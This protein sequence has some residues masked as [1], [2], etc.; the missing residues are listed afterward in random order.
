MQTQANNAQNPLGTEKVRK[1]LPKYAVPSIVSML[2]MAIYNMVDQI[3]IGHYVGYLGNGATTVA[4]PL[5]TIMMALALMVG[6]GSAAAISLSLG[7][8]DSSACRKIIGN[9]L[10]LNLVFSGAIMAVVLT[11]MD[12]VLVFLG[13]QPNVMPYARDYVAV[14]VYGA[15][16]A[17]ISASLG[18]IIRADGSPRY[19]MVANMT[20]AISNIF[21]DWLLMGRGMGVRGAA[22]ATITAQALSMLLV[23][24]YFF[25]QA[26]Y[27]RLELPQMKPAPHIIRQM[28]GLG[29]SSFVTQIGITILNIVLNNS[30]THYGA[31]SEYGAD[32]PLAAIGVVTKINSIIINLILGVAIGA[33]PILGYNYG[34]K[35]YR[36]VR[37]TYRTTITCT[38]IISTVG[39]LA[40]M[41]KPN[42]FIGLF[43]DSDPRFNTFASYVLQ[44]YL[45]AVFASGFQIPSSNYFQAV[46]KPML[47][48]TLT[49][50]RQLLL[51]IPLIL[52]LPRFFGLNG[53]LY[54]GPIADIT[55]ALV[56][57]VFI[58]RELRQL[59]LHIMP[60]DSAVPASG[61]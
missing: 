3:F 42:I 44:V 28:C 4:F 5:V 61:K 2:V 57:A 15:P 38:V 8:G 20:G 59:N 24:Y 33:Q 45:G 46:G 14:I 36:R 7:R 18:N 25:R 56:T 6:N 52:I 55:A 27:T 19:S 30:I 48:M 11:F 17:M 16:F 32:I 26:K 37:E 60:Q 54:A 43:G 35:N 50:T 51:L 53:I 31:M 40:F 21:L 41:F 22:I 13:A 29:S 1:L 23:L 58:A 9:A 49:M 39:W 12:P 10:M 47:S 34:A